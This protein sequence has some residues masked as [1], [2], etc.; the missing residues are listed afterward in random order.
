[1]STAGQDF[2]DCIG[3]TDKC[4]QGNERKKSRAEH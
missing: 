3:P 2:V 4:W 1:M